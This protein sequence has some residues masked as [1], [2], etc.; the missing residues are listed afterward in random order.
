MT[1]CDGPGTKHTVSPGA[2]VTELGENVM[3]EVV[4]VTSQFIVGV[5]SMI[6]TVVET[7]AVVV[8][9]GPLFH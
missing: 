3:P 5:V 2:T 8:E 1:L 7:P 6:D 4:I 9:P